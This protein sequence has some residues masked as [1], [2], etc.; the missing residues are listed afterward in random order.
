MEDMLE[1]LGIH[2][3]LEEKHENVLNLIGIC[4]SAGG[5]RSSCLP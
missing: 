5:K 2:L 4:S 3:K 1:E